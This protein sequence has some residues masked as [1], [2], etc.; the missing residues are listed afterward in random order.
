MCYAVGWFPTRIKE[1]RI[2]LATELEAPQNV[3]NWLFMPLI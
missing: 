1:R 2:A 3:K